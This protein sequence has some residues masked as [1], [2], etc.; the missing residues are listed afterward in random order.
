MLVLVLK[1][2]VDCSPGR[3]MENIIPQKISWQH[4][5]ENIKVICC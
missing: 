4:L 5:L 3:M 2:F 1:F